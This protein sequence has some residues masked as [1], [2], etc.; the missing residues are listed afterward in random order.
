MFDE[1]SE[2]LFYQFTDAPGEPDDIGMVIAALLSEESRDR[3][4]L[5]HPALDR[6]GLQAGQGRAGLGRLPGPLR[7]RLAEIHNRYGHG[8]VVRRSIQRATPMI[9]RA[10]EQVQD[11]AARDA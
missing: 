3:A 1:T 7:C 4:D 5:R 9:L 11:R 6:A 2:V 8:H 10:V